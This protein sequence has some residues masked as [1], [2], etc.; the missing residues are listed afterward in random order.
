M[1]SRI[2]QLAT[3]AGVSTALT[4]IAVF[5]AACSR[6]GDNSDIAVDGSTDAAFE[7]RADRSADTLAVDTQSDVP[8]SDWPG[9]TR[10]RGLGVDCPLDIAIDPIASAPPINWIAC[11]DGRPNCLEIDSTP[12]SSEIIKF[13][14][15]WFSRDG[16]AFLLAHWISS[17]VVAEF[18]VYETATLK[19]VVAWRSDYTN[20]PQ[21]YC[22]VS[23]AFGDTIMGALY[24]HSFDGGDIQQA[25]AFAKP[26]QF[27]DAALTPLPSLSG[28][29]TAH[30]SL[31]DTT[32]AIDMNLSHTVARSPTNNLQ[33]A[34]TKWPFQ[35]DLDT[36]TVVHDDVYA[37]SEHGGGDG[38]HREAKLES[39]AAVTI[40][41]E[42]PQRH[43]T[44][45]V[46]DG[47]YW[48]WAESYGTGNP[49]DNPQPNVDIYTAPYTSSSATLDATKNKLASIGPGLPRGVIA[50]PGHF[51]LQNVPGQ[52][53]VFRTSDGHR[54][55]VADQGSTGCWLPL[56]ASDTEFWC[57]EKVAPNGP[58]GVRV[59]KRSLPSW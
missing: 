13:G 56:Y 5:G 50:A 29:V 32:F 21:L 41:R 14:N 26:S 12:F 33:I 42:V 38:W 25:V 40:F 10:V 24:A 22:G 55:T 34:R 17:D 48:F 35:I 54:T 8:T 39:D 15:G 9:W 57:I 44:A 37:S 27:I 45:M 47:S 58:N 19:P 28:D 18:D 49:N 46:T 3:R 52:L 1:T 11:K 23:S 4:C 53:E 16:K 20:A 59:T 7:R 31:S 36:P 2:H 43:I 6:C 30:F 51:I